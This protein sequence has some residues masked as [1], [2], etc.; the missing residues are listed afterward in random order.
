MTGGRITF[1]QT[2]QAPP[3]ML[4]VGSDQDTELMMGPE[5]IPVTGGSDLSRLIDHRTPYCLMHVT[6]DYFEQAP[7]RP[8]LNPFRTVLNLVTDPDQNPLV[9]ANIEQVLGGFAG[10]VINRAE[11]VLSTT[12]D[13]VADLLAGIPGL[14]V[15]KAIRLDGAKRDSIGITLAQAEFTFPA[16]LRRAGTHSGEFIGRFDNAEQV[17]DAMA[18]TGDHIATEFVDFASSDGLYRKF[19]VFFIGVH[20]VFRHM[21]VSDSWNVHAKSRT[22]FMASRPD[23]ILE[24]ERVLASP[25]GGLSEELLGAFRDVR[26]RFPL[27]Y[28]GMDFGIA[29]NGKLLLFE[30]NATMNFFPFLDDPCFDYV[31]QSARPAQL[32][33]HKLI[34]LPIAR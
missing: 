18:G 21:L 11:A 19:R 9:L 31:K 6:K 16:L 2:P 25:S 28:F 1:A 23:L 3:L 33:I 5:P 10:K 34:E 15:P 14:I 26:Q 24:E 29:P 32:A 13:K 4:I 17:A 7:C 20:L 12:R 27:D 30:A 22:E 8:N